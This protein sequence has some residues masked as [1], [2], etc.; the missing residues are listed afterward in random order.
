[1][2]KFALLLIS[3]TTAFMVNA[4]SPVNIGLKAGVN[5]SKIKTDMSQFDEGNVNNFFAGAFLRINL[6]KLYLQPEAYFSSKG[7]DLSSTA[8]NGSFDLKSVD[9]PL[10][11]GYKLIDKKIVNLRI[12][13]GP[14]MSFMTNSSADGL[15]E[16]NADK[17]K[18]HVFGWQYGAG[19]D[20]LFLTLDVRMENSFGDIYSGEGDAKN[21]TFL[22]SLGI[23]LL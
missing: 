19:V 21:R 3:M 17:I 1:M 16:F 20:F 11:L 13:T 8:E 18:D 23:M 22:V 7:G 9:V 5:S 4:Q 2:K 10:L 6:R 12:H 15:T 14:V